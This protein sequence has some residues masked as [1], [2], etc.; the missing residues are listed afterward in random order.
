[1]R[2]MATRKISST[3]TAQQNGNSLMKAFRQIDMLD[4]LKEPCL[5]GSNNP[6]LIPY[7][8]RSRSRT[9]LVHILSNV[10]GNGVY[11]HMPEAIAQSARMKPAAIHEG[12]SILKVRR[13]YKVTTE[14]TVIVHQSD[15]MRP[16]MPLPPF[17]PNEGVDMHLA[18]CFGRVAAVVHHLNNKRSN[19]KHKT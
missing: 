17:S 1:M 9:A 10:S 4:D 5:A 16:T 8:P 6:Q 3:T 13:V 14:N 2:R 18:N 7:V 19:K 12:R 15:T 11:T